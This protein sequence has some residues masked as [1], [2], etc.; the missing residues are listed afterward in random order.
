MKK[1]R[2]RV[3]MVGPDRQVHGGI[4]AMVNTYYE[5]GLADRVQLKYIGTMKEGSKARK[6]A[7]AVLAYFEFLSSLRDCDIVHVN[8]SSDSSLMR[9]SFFV[10]AAHRCGKKI[11]FHQHGG[12]FQNYFENQISEKRRRYIRDILDMSDVMLVLT[13]SWKEYF[14]KLTDK[15]K[16]IVMPNG[17]WTGGA[18]ASYKG[19]D[20]SDS[21]Y[22]S[23]NGGY[24]SGNGEA[25]DLQ[26]VLFLGRICK[27]KGVTE[28]LEAMDRIHE[29][30]P[31]AKLYIGGVFED[32]SYIAEFEKR[33]VYVKYL[34]W[35]E[36]EAKDRIYGE[37]GIVA[38]PSYF[39]GFGLT[40]IEGMQRGCCVV[41]SNVGGIPEIVEDGR[42]GILVKPK[43][44]VSL[45]E[46]LLKVMDKEIDVD[47]LVRCGREKVREKYSAER[48]VQRIFEI[49]EK[50]YAE[51]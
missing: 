8:A 42:D 19:T 22:V 50:L 12:D 24:V 46:A 49:Y 27:D 1:D 10:S 25:H 31:S 20:G 15:D 18:G 16:I 37:C 21:G 43:D 17:I 48:I 9:K 7:V 41:A 32:D 6:L 4:S 14:G 30:K 39:E 45:E 11:V 38:V 44:S 29:K 26:K 36:K 23:G 34:G 51:H 40:V 13:D 5:A 28:L 47:S 35:V 3:L 33:S 2:I